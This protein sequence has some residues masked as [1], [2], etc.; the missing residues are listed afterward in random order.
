MTL[1]LLASILAL[2]VGPLIYQGT[3]GRVAASAVDAFAL[4]GVAGLV[5]VHILPQSLAIGGWLVIPIVLVGLFGPGLLCGSPLFHGRE[6][7][8]VA[9]PLALLAIALHAILDGLALAPHAHAAGRGA[10]ELAFAVVLHR[11]PVGLGIWWLV[12]PLYGLRAAL[13]LVLGI[14]VFTAVGSISGEAI[15]AR[16]PQE[17]IALLQALLAGSLLHVILRHP[18]SLDT[19]SALAR[20]ASAAGGLAAVAVVIGMGSLHFHQHHDHEEAGAA[21]TFVDLALESAPALLLAYVAVGFAHALLPDLHRLLGRGSRLN[22]ALRGTAVG[23]PVPIC[24]CGVIPLYRS[25]V[26]GGVPATAAL[27]FLVATPELGIA[28]LVLSV[29]LLGFEVTLARAAAAFVLALVVGLV[30]GRVAKMPAAAAPPDTQASGREP[31][32]RRLGTGMRYGFGEMV[33]ATAPW[34]I[35]GIAVAALADPLI[36]SET[37]TSLPAGL[38]VPLFALIGMPIYVCASGSTPLVAVLLGKGT[39]VGAAIAFLLTGPATNLTTF[40]VL[41]KLHGRRAA[42]LFAGL[43]VVV[44]VAIGYAV[45]LTLPASAAA[46]LPALEEHAPSTFKTVCLAL[47]ALLYLVSL[48]RQGVRGF[49]GQV[50]APHSHDDHDDHGDACHAHGDESDHVGHAHGAA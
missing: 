42:L 23:L 20:A 6:S 45:N 3:R 10:S 12:R 16:A 13:I 44:A 17:A 21:G 24:S 37:L 27:A 25:L 15:V 49:L 46:S 38:D 39:S 29:Q 34:L 5:F 18:P 26:L 35:V 32:R 28:A 31:L 47:I 1:P 11:V 33:D 36:R 2:L 22:Q 7:R 4:V 50:I 41:T 19:S 14:A 30:V 40:G 43:A 48:F 8:V 9:M